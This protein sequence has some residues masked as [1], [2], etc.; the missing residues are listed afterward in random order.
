AVA[1]GNLG[2]KG[3]A[4]LR[5][6]V[7]AMGRWHA[8]AMDGA[9]NHV[10]LAERILDESGYTGMWQADKAPDAPGRLD[11]LKELVKALEEFDNL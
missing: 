7:T 8:D 4:N 9:V 1:N 10:E 6:F 2:G 3:A 5:G 11:N